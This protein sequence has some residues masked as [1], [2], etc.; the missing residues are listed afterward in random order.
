MSNM[1]NKLLEDQERRENEMKRQIDS[2][3]T[4]IDGNN[5]ALS[6]KFDGVIIHVKSI[7]NK[8]TQMI[9]DCEAHTMDLE[10]DV[11]ED[12]QIK[13]ETQ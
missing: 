13:N 9:E 6:S 7:N 3:S 10:G 11:E 4:K 12:V 1:L 8:L 2:L 5:K